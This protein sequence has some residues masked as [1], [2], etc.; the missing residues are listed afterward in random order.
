MYT[1]GRLSPQFIMR[2]R[3]SNKFVDIP[4]NGTSKVKII[5]NNKKGIT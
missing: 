3:K 2:Y 4:E 1:L 5:E